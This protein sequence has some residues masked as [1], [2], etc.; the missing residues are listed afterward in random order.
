MDFQ[1]ENQAIK[2]IGLKHYTRATNSNLMY[3]YKDIV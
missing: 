2:N 1:T 3:N